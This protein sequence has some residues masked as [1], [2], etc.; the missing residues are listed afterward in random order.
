MLTI[1]DVRPDELDEVAGLLEASYAEYGP[2]DTSSDDLVKAF[3]EYQ[4]ELRDVRSRLA[5]S[6]LI[7][8]EHDGRIAGAVT[9]YPPG[10]EKK[11]EG[12]PKEWAAFRLLAVHPTARGLGIGKALTEECMRRARKLGATTMGLH[13]TIVMGVAR[14]MY[15]RMGFMRFPENDFHITDGFTVM[16]YSLEL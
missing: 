15:E 11:A 9:F 4:N 14:A 8:A 1:R 2:P 12:W 3:E 6:V 13:T 7:V 10:N 5:D 16:A